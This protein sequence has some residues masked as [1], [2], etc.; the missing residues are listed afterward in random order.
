M[1]DSHIIAAARAADAQPLFFPEMESEA[2]EYLEQQGHSTGERLF[3]RDRKRYDS[4]VRLLA[5]GKISEKEIAKAY[6]VSR[7]TISGIRKREQIPIEQV[8][9]KILENVR[10]A[11]Q[12]TSERI[13]ELAPTASIKDATIAFGVLTQNHQLLSGEATSI[14]AN[15]GDKAKHA[16]FNEMLATLPAADVS[17]IEA[18]TTPVEMGSS[19]G[20]LEQKGLPGA[21]LDEAA[22]HTESIV[23]QKETGRSNTQGNKSGDSQ[24]EGRASGLD[25]P[26]EGG[27]GSNDDAGASN[28]N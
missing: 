1:S 16:S 8:K 24:A 6:G 13:V 3:Q 2:L 11:M 20:K 25:S 12:L 19:G 4:I 26:S 9:A 22:G 7:N 17:V 27:R 23:L 18:E 15:V 5:D 28:T 14:V 10:E 21:G